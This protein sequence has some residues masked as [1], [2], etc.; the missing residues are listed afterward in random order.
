MMGNCPTSRCNGPGARV[1]RLPAERGVG[2]TGPS[3]NDDTKIRL[4]SSANAVKRLLRVFRRWGPIAAAL[5]LA[6][7]VVPLVVEAQQALK[8]P[9]VGVL[10]GFSTEGSPRI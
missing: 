6:L 8:V 4:Q 9:R 2:Q 10:T 5:T 3:D 7:L 1:A